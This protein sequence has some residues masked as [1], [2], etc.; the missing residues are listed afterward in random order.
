ME[1]R[2]SGISVVARLLFGLP[3]AAVLSVIGMAI[4]SAMSVFFG[5]S[6]LPTL[7]ALLT[8]GAGIGAGIGGAAM[9]FRV[10]AIPPWPFLI[11]VVVTL[12]ALSALGAWAGL[13]I[14]DRITTIQE[15]NCVGVCDYFF[16]PRTYMALGAIVVSNAVV[17]A[18]N[19]A[20]ET[21]VAGWA[22]ARLRPG[23]A[24]VRGSSHANSGD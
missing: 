19:I 16:K 6:G 18:S 17:L 2:K 21:R 11:L 5:V 24:E 9:L 20:Y 15:M 4:A 12:S 23:D 13:T 8:I 1:W 3:L 7:L 14:G 10:D 22:F